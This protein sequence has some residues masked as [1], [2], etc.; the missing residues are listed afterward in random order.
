MGLPGLR[1]RCPGIREPQAFSGE[2]LSIWTV[3]RL[4]RGG[5]TVRPFKDF[6]AVQ[7]FRCVATTP[8]KAGKL[9]PN[10]TGPGSKRRAALWQPATSPPSKG[11]GGSSSSVGKGRPRQ[12]R[13]SR[14]RSPSRHARLSDLPWQPCFTLRSRPLSLQGERRR[15]RRAAS[16]QAHQPAGREGLCRPLIGWEQSSGPAAARVIRLLASG[17]PWRGSAC[18]SVQW[19]VPASRSKQWTGK[20]AR[21]EILEQGFFLDLLIAGKRRRGGVL[22]SFRSSGVHRFAYW[23]D[24]LEHRSIGPNQVGAE[25]FLGIWGSLLLLSS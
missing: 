22:C 12:K 13:L 24:A 25:S 20:A 4:G 3:H 2:K 21:G 8:P 18:W 11:G 6:A 23:S 14:L 1:A 15:R 19:T 10:R 7:V 17:L 16:S 5:N 9:A